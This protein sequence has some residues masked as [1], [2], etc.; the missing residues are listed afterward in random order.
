MSTKK[1][2]AIGDNNSFYMYKSYDTNEGIE[3]LTKKLEGARELDMF[4]TTGK[5]FLDNK[6]V[7][8]ALRKFLENGGVIKMLCG[9]PGSEFVEEVAQIENPE[10]GDRSFIHK[11]YQVAL[12][13]FVQILNVSKKECDQKGTVLGSIFVGNCNTLFRSS[14]L[15]VKTDNDNYWGWLKPTLPP[16]KSEIMRGIELERNKSN[17]K[18][19]LTEHA[20]E[21]FDKVWEYAKKH[22]RITQLSYDVDI[23]KIL[24]NKEKSQAEEIEELKNKIEDGKKKLLV[25]RLFCVLAVVLMIVS[26]YID[27]TWIKC[28]L[29]ITGFVSGIL[30]I[31]HSPLYDLVKKNNKKN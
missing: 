1:S 18:N 25:C 11:E 4:F 5:G 31:M 24:D 30:T 20:L 28:I 19:D 10:Y 27:K 7:Q 16:L 15:I 29:E 13:T 17:Y 23:N 2:E 12:D 8:E 3:L 14:I 26:I 9:N 21:H 6:I 22:D